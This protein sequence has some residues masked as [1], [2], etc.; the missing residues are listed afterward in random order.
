[1]GYKQSR[2]DFEK[3]NYFQTKLFILAILVTYFS[4]GFL[5]R[6]GKLGR[7]NDP[8]L[9]PFFSW[10]LF[11]EVVRE[12]EE[13]HTIRILALEG[14]KLDPPIYFNDAE[15]LFE[16]HLE[17]APQTWYVLFEELAESLEK[18]RAD[19]VGILRSRI[20]KNLLA[21]EVEYEVVKIKFKPANFYKDRKV[22]K[23]KAYGV[24]SKRKR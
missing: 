12:V 19:R 10:A 17:N 11:S 18:S 8:R 22:L 15:Q 4:V 2:Q 9:F 6:Y 23:V 21:E 13:Y 16:R 14:E 24:L 3:M 1:M 5:M 20:D 7:E